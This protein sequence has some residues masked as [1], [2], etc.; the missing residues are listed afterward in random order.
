[1]AVRISS[2]AQLFFP[3]RFMKKVLAVVLLLAVSYTAAAADLYGFIEPR[4]TTSRMAGEGSTYAREVYGFASYGG[5]IGAF[6]FGQTTLD[7]DDEAFSQAYVGP[8]WRPTEWLEVGIGYGKEWF[9]GEESRASSGRLGSYID[10]TT[11]YGYAELVFENGDSG[12]YYEARVSYEP[13]DWL[14]LGGIW[15]QHLGLGPRIEFKIPIVENTV[16]LNVWGAY[17]TG[18]SDEQPDNTLMFSGQIEVEFPDF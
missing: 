13:T 9:D 10:V 17:L 18:S 3:G 7:T 15:F 14:G 2:S 11:D 1:M 4:T 6:V 12:F 5:T 8:Y 16:R